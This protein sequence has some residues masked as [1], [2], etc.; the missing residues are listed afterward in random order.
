MDGNNLK[1]VI[2]AGGMGTRLAE[3]TQNIPKPLVKIGKDPIILHIINLYQK[4]KV[5]DF[6]VLTGYKGKE[7]VKY[8]HKSKSFDLLSKN[9]QVHSF[10]N[11]KKSFKIT[12]I[13]TGKA[14]KTGLRLKKIKKYIYKNE[15]FFLT[16]GDGLTNANLKKTY[17]YHLKK[18]AHI[19]ILAVRPPARF[20][21]IIF[22]G[23]RIKSFEEKNSINTGW[24]NGGFMIINQSFFS[25][26]SNKNQMLEREPFQSCIKK[27][28]LYAYKHAG[29]WQCMDNLRDKILLD[30]LAKR[31]KIPWY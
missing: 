10:I 5:K 17:D 15:N 12:L 3:Y 14:T 2:L 6:Y 26:L 23:S 1:A 20:G 28:K 25:Y 16:Y 29:F 31:K 30:K 18:K 7:L 21:E 22:T 19:T 11:K 4:V 27:N 9:K 13:D 8:F 24:I